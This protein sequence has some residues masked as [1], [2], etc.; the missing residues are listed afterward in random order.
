MNIQDFKTKN[1]IAYDMFVRDRLETLHR[2]L[3]ED[4]TDVA[5]GAMEYGYKFI[6]ESKNVLKEVSKLTSDLSLS[7]MNAKHDK[8][9]LTSEEEQD[10]KEMKDLID[11]LGNMQFKLNKVIQK[12]ETLKKDASELV[13]LSTSFAQ[14]IINAQEKFRNIRIDI[15]DYGFLSSDPKIAHQIS[16]QK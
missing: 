8:K 6:P 14:D 2:L 15:N 13:T 10:Y 9:A 1:T 3:G 11:D 16:D 4:V 5:D 7:L 12:I